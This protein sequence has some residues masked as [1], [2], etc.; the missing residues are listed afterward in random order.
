MLAA[1]VFAAC[2]LTADARIAGSSCA[3]HMM[4]HPHAK[5]CFAAGSSTNGVDDDGLD[6]NNAPDLNYQK[7]YGSKYQCIDCLLAAPTILQWGCTIQSLVRGY[8]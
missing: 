2:W 8:A 4:N 6:A 3:Q 7:K 1:A 5:A